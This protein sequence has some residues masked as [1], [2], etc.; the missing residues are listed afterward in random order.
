MKS[1]NSESCFNTEGINAEFKKLR[2]RIEKLE[3][4]ILANG[5]DMG[6]ISMNINKEKRG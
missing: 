3:S 5:L 6:N 4:I 1:V 2:K